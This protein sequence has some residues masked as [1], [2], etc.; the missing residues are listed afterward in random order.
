MKKLL[1]VASL[2][3][4]FAAANAMAD[5]A[6]SATASWDATATKDT[7]SMLVVTPLNSLTFQYA[8]GLNGFNS[9]DGAFDVTIQGQDTATD[10]EL[11][12]QIVSNTLTNVSGDDSTLNVGVAWNGTALSNATETVLVNASSTSGLE[13]LMADGAYNGTERVS[14]Q[15]SFK[16]TI[17]S[18]TSDGTTPVSD[19]SA[20]PD[21]YWSG[22]VKVQFNATW[23]TP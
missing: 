22:D 19:Y 23:T 4:V 9:Q 8:E 3:S 14:D 2:A 17:A 20:L 11:T 1:L 7:T 10:F 6:A 18:A 15:S 12:A 5:V 13:S 21:G 16:F